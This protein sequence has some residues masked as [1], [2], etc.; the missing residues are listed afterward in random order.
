[1]YASQSVAEKLLEKGS[2]TA[3]QFASARSESL[4]SGVA[5]EDALRAQ[6]VI[7]GV[8]IAKAKS[9]IYN[10]P[11]ID[12]LDFKIPDDALNKLSEDVVRRYMVIPF[13]LSAGTLKVAM[14][15]PLDILAIN[16]VSKISGL[17]VIPYYADPAAIE[18]V[19]D[20]FYKEKIVGKVTEAVSEVAVEAP[21]EAEEQIAD[22]SK[23]E[24]AIKRAP[25]AR[26][27]NML[28][29][30]AIK[31][32]ASDIHIEPRGQ[33]VRVRFRIHGV[34]TEKLTV[35][36]SVHPALV[37]RIKILSKLKIDEKRIPQDGRFS[38]K[39]GEHEIDLRVSTLPTVYGEKVVL[40]I[41]EQAGG[42]PKLEESGLRG[43]AFNVYVDSLSLTSGIILVTGPTGSGKSTTLAGSLARVN[44]EGINIIT[45]ENPVEIRVDGVNQVQIN[46]DAGLTFASGLRSILRQDPD[47]I[48]VGEI[49]DEETANLAVQAALTGHLVLSTLHT[50][51]AAGALPR[52]LDMKIEPYLIASTVKLVVAQRLPRTICENCM[53]SYIASPEVVQDIRKVLGNLEIDIVNHS[54]THCA[55]EQT[56]KSCMHKQIEKDDVPDIDQLV[57]FRGKGCDKCNGTGYQGRIGI[58]EVMN[59]TE[60]IGKLIME[61]KPASM[62][63]NAA[64]EDGMITMIQDGYLKA[65][66]GRTTIEEVLR[67]SKS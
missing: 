46:P 5:V 25:V 55:L 50:N 47:V 48:M 43:S 53:E 37:S 26:I 12:L 11:Y 28:L 65:L 7:T 67:V 23:A 6:G 13:E 31:S 63:E 18:K 42:I 52:L 30:F 60:R 56:G 57:L 24:E 39:L 29:E 61:N 27:I 64:R 4:R 44:R 38:F 59:V 45:L 20:S 8:D 33:D 22:I 66:E 19:I 15:D 54:K 62:L 14:K 16:Y 10:V 9:E 3:D 51:S 49:R 21:E 34:L 36:L 2:I 35:P 17:R 41:L 32:H 1:M 40:R 58:Y